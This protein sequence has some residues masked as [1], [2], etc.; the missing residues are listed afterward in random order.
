MKTL[1]LLACLLLPRLASAATVDFGS[2]NVDEKHVLLTEKPEYIHVIFDAYPYRQKISELGKKFTLL[3][4]AKELAQSYVFVKFPKARKAKIVIVEYAER[5]EYGSPVWEHVVKLG[6][7][8]A[9]KKGKSVTVKA[10]SKAG[11]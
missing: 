3:R 8:E 9:G 1:M 6:E 10:L 5:D 7:F 2:L 4:A 11:K